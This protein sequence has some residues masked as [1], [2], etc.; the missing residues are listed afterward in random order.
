ML[1]SFQGR[2]A[3]I[4]IFFLR[5]QR[6]GQVHVPEASDGRPGAHEG[7]GAP[8]P[9]V[10]DRPVRP[11]LGGAPH[12]G[13]DAGRVPHEAVQLA[14]G[15]GTLDFYSRLC[16]CFMK[17]YLFLQGPLESTLYHG[18]NLVPRT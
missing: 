3:L 6:R 8:Q 15:E 12:R 9:A 17:Q 2:F 11:A 10:E 4:I 13:R 14:S 1:R 18:E 16:E 7:R 5:T